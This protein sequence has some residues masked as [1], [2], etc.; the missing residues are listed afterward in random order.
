MTYELIA[1]NGRRIEY[2]SV[3]RNVGNAMEEARNLTK[4]Y[5]RVIVNKMS[6]GQTVYI[7][8]RKENL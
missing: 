6:T 2:R 1:M 4:H 7:A 5:D 8:D 3:F